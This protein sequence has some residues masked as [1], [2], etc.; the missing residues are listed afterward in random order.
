MEEVRLA[1]GEKMILALPGLGSAGYQWSVI[2]QDARVA[3]V[4]KI[5][6]LSG[7]APGASGSNDEQF[8]IVALTA[9]QTVLWFAQ[10]RVFQSDRPPH[11]VREVLVRV[12]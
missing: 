7:A 6:R 5:E 8:A 9:G 10:R 1:A 4:A 11:A 2:V 3:H 12:E